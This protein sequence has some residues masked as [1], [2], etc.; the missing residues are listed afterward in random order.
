MKQ[1]L[2]EIS[3]TTFLNCLE[4]ETSE[5]FVEESPAEPSDKV[6]AQGSK[7]HHKVRGRMPG[8]DVDNPHDTEGPN[9]Q[10][11]KSRGEAKVL[12]LVVI[13]YKLYTFKYLYVYILV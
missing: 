5:I 4:S 9:Y 1:Q 13:I 3:E 8:L 12:N 11:D 10:R 7:E 2:L 6:H